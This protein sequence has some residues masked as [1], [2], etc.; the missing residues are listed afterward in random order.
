MTNLPADLRVLLLEDHALIALDVETMLLALGAASVT[1]FTTVEDALSKIDVTPFDVGLIDVQVGTATS[2][3]LAVEL[4]RR[5]VPFAFATGY[6]DFHMIAEELRD[7]P[8]ITKPYKEDD[9]RKTVQA[10]LSRRQQP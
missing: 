2:M 10:L 8:M 3:P 6:A 4:K 9:L 5:G 7:V 1:T